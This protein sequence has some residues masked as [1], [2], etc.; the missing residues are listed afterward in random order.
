[1]GKGKGKLKDWVTQLPSGT[2][3]IEYKNLRYGRSVY[4]LKQMQF[5]IRSESVI[6]R[7]YRYIDLVYSSKV[8]V[9][10]ERR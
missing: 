7:K 4:F 9:P 8:K 1:M 6:I 2:N 10:F 3:I 5:K